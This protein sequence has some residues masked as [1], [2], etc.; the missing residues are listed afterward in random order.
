MRTSVLAAS[1]A[2]AIAMAA[3]PAAAW[4]RG[5]GDFG[6]GWSRTAG[7]SF[8]HSGDAG[9]FEHSTAVGPNGVAHDSDAGGYWHGSAANGYGA[10][11]GS[12]YGGYYHGTT[13]NGYGAWHTGAYGDYYHQPAYVN[14]YGGSCWNC[15]VGGWGVAAGV[16]AGAVAG[17]AVTAA[18]ADTAAASWAIGSSYG[19]LPASCS[20][21]NIAGSVYYACGFGWMKPVYGANGV[22]Y[23]VVPAP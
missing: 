3:Q 19:Y 11:H 10:Y 1:V 12:T 4:M 22:Y 13:T 8:E 15:G 20:Y 16:A 7:G 9:G 2:L 17:A 21:D 18:A 23:R 14:S 6:G 5:G